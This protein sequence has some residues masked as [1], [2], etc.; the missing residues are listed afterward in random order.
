MNLE[1]IINN[2]KDAKEVRI[3]FVSDVKL[4]GGKKNPLQGLVEKE[5]LKARVELTRK[6]TY[7]N[8]VKARLISEG[9]NPDEFKVQKRPWGT[10][11]G[12]SPII[13]H[14]GNKYLECIFL[15][16]PDVAAKYYVNGYEHDPSLIEGFRN[17]N[18]SKELVNSIILR[19]IKFENLTEIEI[20]G[21]YF[22]K[23]TTDWAEMFF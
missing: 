13:E 12:D 17:V 9:K 16:N 1:E 15:N 22:W 4:T 19:C 2:N 21:K 6:D 5:V 23:R 10:R 8:E 18:E 11:I 3:S 7:S 14:K 20:D